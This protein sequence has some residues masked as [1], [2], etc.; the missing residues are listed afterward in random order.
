M[1]RVL[2]QSKGFISM[3]YPYPHILK[4]V[5]GNRYYPNTKISRIQL[6]CV[7]RS[8]YLSHKRDFT[9]HP[10]TIYVP[11]VHWSQTWSLQSHYATPFNHMST[12]L[13]QPPTSLSP[14]PFFPFACTCHFLHFYT[15]FDYIWCSTK[16]GLH[17]LALLGWFHSKRTV[18]LLESPLQPNSGPV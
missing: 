10:L 13:F 1:G 6:Y 14:D 5:F 4:Q 16:F 11:A 7:L 15:Y 18:F 17:K 9:K 12:S 8:L 3:K 2:H